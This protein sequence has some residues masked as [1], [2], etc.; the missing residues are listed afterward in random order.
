MTQTTVELKLLT[1][2][3]GIIR[4]WSQEKEISNS[5]LKY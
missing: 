3:V 2:S 4:L 1:G 5:D